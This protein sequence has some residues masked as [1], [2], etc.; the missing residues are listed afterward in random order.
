MSNEYR[1]EIDLLRNLVLKVNEKEAFFIKEIADK[2]DNLGDLNTTLADEIKLQVTEIKDG[3]AEYNRTLGVWCFYHTI[4]K[5]ILK[6]DAYDIEY[7]KKIYFSNRELSND[8]F[9][10][11]KERLMKLHTK[12]KINS[13]RNKLE[14]ELPEEFE[15]LASS[16]KRV[17]KIIEFDE[18]IF[19]DDEPIF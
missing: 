12:Y 16:F 5:I 10:D 1:V 17:F 4:E 19:E 15:Y 7:L 3:E 14:C 13:D 6:V 2:L 9:Y 18:N 11:F 8:E